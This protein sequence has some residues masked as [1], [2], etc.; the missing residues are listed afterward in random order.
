MVCSNV[1]SICIPK[2]IAE[3]K[4]GFVFQ[5]YNLFPNMTVERNLKY[6]SNHGINEEIRRLIN[7]T[8]LEKCLQSYPH[9]LSG[10]QKQRVSVIRALCQKPDLLLLDEPFSALDDEAIGKFIKEIKF[11]Q[12]SLGTMVI[13]VSHRKDV[14]FEVANSVVNMVNSSEVVQGKPEELLKREF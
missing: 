3:R 12:E 13:L 5:D 10:G 1:I 7:V 11:I 8:D 9:Q 6:A 14:I 4:L 2:S